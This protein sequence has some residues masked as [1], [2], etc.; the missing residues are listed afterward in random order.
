MIVDGYRRQYNGLLDILK[1]IFSILIVFSHG[2]FW[3]GEGDKLVFGYALIGVEFFFVIS[4]YLLVN[5]IYTN[6]LSI[7]DYIIRRIKGLYGYFIMAFIFCSSVWLYLLIINERPEKW[8][9]FT[10]ILKL[11]FEFAFMNSS[12]ISIVGV[13]GTWWYISAMLFSEWLIYPII[14]YKESWYLYYAAPLSVFLISG[15]MSF[16]FGTIATGG[17]SGFIK[18]DNLRAILGVVCGTLVFYFVEKLK[19]YEIKKYVIYVCDLI[20]ILGYGVIWLIAYNN[21][22]TIHSYVDGNLG[23]VTLPILFVCVSITCLNEFTK[24]ESVCKY[25]GKLSTCIYLVHWQCM[26]LVKSF[27]ERKILNVGN[28]TY[29]EKLIALF[30]C[31]FIIS[32]TILWISD[33]IKRNISKNKDR[34]FEHL[35]EHGL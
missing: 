14:R 4:G 35:I 24:W 33:S 9:L 25:L 12:G 29:H 10:Y 19:N 6:K 13:N 22:P 26:E 15:Y 11:P 5:S 32:N 16:N 21:T 17:W 27:Y 2:I 3:A 7:R 23:F 8:T 28:A 31:S 1:F 30:I 34:I 20:A 18:T